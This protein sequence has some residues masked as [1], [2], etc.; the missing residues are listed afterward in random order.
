MRPVYHVPFTVPSIRALTAKAGSRANR[1]PAR[2]KVIFNNA[3]RDHGA[4]AEGFTPP[5]GL[6][7]SRLAA[8]DGR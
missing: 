3:V 6:V 5:F 7:T 8:A 1:F 2:A 4:T